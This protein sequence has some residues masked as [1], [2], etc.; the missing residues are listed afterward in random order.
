MRAMT[1]L[2]KRKN[3]RSIYIKEM[4]AKVENDNIVSYGVN[5]KISFELER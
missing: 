4:E 2:T 1:E 3:I 5:A